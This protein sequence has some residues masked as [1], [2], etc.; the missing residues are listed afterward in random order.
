M[1]FSSI[2][3][4]YFFL[5][6]VLV[7]YMLVP[8][9]FKNIIL[10]IFGLLFYSW[11]EP[12]YFW[13]MIVS[14]LVDYAAGIYMNMTESTAKR[15]TA[16]VVSMVVDLGFLFVF[17]YSGFFVGLINSVFGTNITK[18]DLPLPVGISFY[19]FQSMSYTIDIYR[20]NAKVQKNFIDYLTYVS[21]FPQLVAGPI[22]RYN[23]VAD[24]LTDRKANVDSLGEGAALFIKGLAKKALIANNIGALWTEVKGMDYSQISVLTAWLGILAF[25]YQIY[26]DFSGYSD[27]ARG[28][29]KMF[30]FDF[31]VNF[32]HPYQSRSISE[33]WR[34]WHITLGAWFR[35]YLYIPL[36]GNRRG[37]ARTYL[38]LVIVWLLTGFW[39]GASFN[40]IFWGLF[41]GILI[42]AERAGFSKVL[43]KLPSSFSMLYTFLMVMFGWIMF[44]LDTMSGFLA[45]LRAMFTGKFFDSLSLYQLSTYGVMFVICIFAS[46][47]LFRRLC[48][49]LAKNG[50]AEKI[51]Y[52]AAPV[53]QIL[54]LLL[55]TCYL[56]DASYNPF[57]YFRF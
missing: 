33:F 4:L 23:D 11:G 19:T 50:K 12:A 16:L 35:E 34:R 37:K 6:L 17:K 24:A 26:F 42:I 10:L 31:P 57:L 27:M 40:F 53:M 20:K 54:L 25:T 21:L 1:V 13:V 18:P 5:P 9:K 8:K 44:D 22:V 56:V 29:G 3:F 41:Y 7:V 28:L 49:R 38:N 14:S 32:D 36:G 47:D 48:D 45:Y 2:T 30:G 46:T 51:L 15:R 43:E 39:H 55:C 52:G